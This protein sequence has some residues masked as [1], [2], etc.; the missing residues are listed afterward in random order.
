ME[1]LG[2]LHFP[3]YPLQMILHLYCTNNLISPL[4]T[5]KEETLKT[6]FGGRGLLWNVWNSTR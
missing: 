5:S 6:Y 3:L 1:R 4:L 2:V